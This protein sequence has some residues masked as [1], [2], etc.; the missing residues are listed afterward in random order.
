MITALSKNGLSARLTAPTKGNPRL[1]Y[2]TQAIDIP[3]GLPGGERRRM[4]EKDTKR[5]YEH[6]EAQGRKKPRVWALHIAGRKNEEIA[7][8]LSLAPKLV[9]LWTKQL[10]EAVRNAERN[11]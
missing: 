3:P 7:K 4:S 2:I 10:G 6:M 5:K 8:R 1:V 11:V 9:E